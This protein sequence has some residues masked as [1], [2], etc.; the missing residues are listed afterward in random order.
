MVSRPPRPLA[1]LAPVNVLLSDH[2]LTFIPLKIFYSTKSDNF[3]IK[4]Y[5]YLKREAHVYNVTPHCLLVADHIAIFP[6]I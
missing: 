5:R 2:S 3:V 1:R 4:Y 6:Q